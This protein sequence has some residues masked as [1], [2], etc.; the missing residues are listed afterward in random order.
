MV[1]KMKDA[2]GMSLVRKS[3]ILTGLSLPD[4]GKWSVNQLSSKLQALI[5]KH[6]DIWTGKFVPKI[7]IRRF[8]RD[9]VVRDEQSGK[10]VL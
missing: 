5:K 8:A 3:F 7:D 2:N 4:S 6:P 10:E 1:N 9:K